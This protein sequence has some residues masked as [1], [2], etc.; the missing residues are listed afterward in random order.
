MIGN[1]NQNITWD[2]NN[3]TLEINE[4]L[5]VGNY[6]SHLSFS[7]QNTVIH[8]NISFEII[9]TVDIYN[10][11][12]SS[13]SSGMSII[14]RPS[15]NIPIEIETGNDATCFI[16]INDMNYCQGTGSNGQ[17]GYGSTGKSNNP[18]K[19]QVF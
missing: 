14:D 16:T 18:N 11:R 10:D 1:S 19:D 9:Y 12:I 8:I 6:T 13:H 17:L 3:H 7:N 2:E 15:Y 4:R 5:L